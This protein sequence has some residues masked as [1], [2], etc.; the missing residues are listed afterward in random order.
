MTALC[1]MDDSAADA[2]LQLRRGDFSP[3][4]QWAAF[5]L[6]GK[7]EGRWNTSG[8]IATEH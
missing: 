6:A 4:S 1:F 8:A 5:T 7:P 2:Q 3:L